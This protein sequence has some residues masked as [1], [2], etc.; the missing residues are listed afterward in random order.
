M[1]RRTL[2]A[3]ACLAA[4]GCAT[5]GA[6]FQRGRPVEVAPAGAGHLYRQ[7][8]QMVRLDDLLAG[9]DTPGP[10]QAEASAARGWMGGGTVL[11]AIGGAGVGYGLVAGIRGDKG[12]WAILGGGAAVTGVA[13]LCASA[14]DGHLLKAV[15]LYNGGLASPSTSSLSPWIAPA[16][17]GGL[18]LGVDG[19]F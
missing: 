1:T 6:P 10:A 11:A 7:G 2:A 8:G 18:L 5:P 12:G 3:V 9:L 19:R 16:G 4:V 15:E 13:L 14:A 17:S